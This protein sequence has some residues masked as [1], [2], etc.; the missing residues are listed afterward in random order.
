MNVF[1]VKRQQDLIKAFIKKVRLDCEIVEL[2]CGDGSN[3]E[4]FSRANLT[5]QGYDIS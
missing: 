3:L 2:G 1:I 5:G 4:S